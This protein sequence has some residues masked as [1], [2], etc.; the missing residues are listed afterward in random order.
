[1]ATCA[2]LGLS[3]AL[4]SGCGRSPASGALALPPGGKLYHGVY[5]GS[6]ANPGSEDSL[7]PQDVDSYEQAVG[8][9]AAWIYF[10]HEWSHGTAF[11]RATAEWIRARGS[12]PF[13]RLM[14]RS[15]TEQ[16]VAEPKWTLPAIAAG[17]FDADLGAWAE[18]ARAFATPLLAEWGTEMNGQWFSWNGTYHGGAQGGTAQFR[19]AYA[20]I[21]EVVRANGAGN[22]TWAF[23]V[24]GDDV[25]T[26]AWNRFENYYPGDAWVDWIGFSQYGASSH[27]A[28]CPDFV[29][30][31]DPTVAR[32]VAMA[33][34]KP[35][36]VFEFG[37]TAD[38]TACASSAAGWADAALR[39][40]VTGRW[41]AVRG[42]AWWNE[43]W[44]NGGSVGWTDMRVQDAPD[45]AGSFLK[46]LG[47]GTT[48]DRPVLQ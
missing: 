31:A 38:A 39:A 24:N 6:L 12:I 15:T 10:S 29:Q 40:L 41:P 37:V 9:R 3:G 17:Q 21:V 28:E 32:L 46:A 7:T 23:H 42:F 13:L 45:L 16:N 1:M 27:N 8:H 34:G 36:F 22:V 20:H 48:V 30:S 19:A 4:G 11:P 18:A 25:P 26:D 47:A 35:V 33:P 2:V 5:P 14:L 44:E 43:K